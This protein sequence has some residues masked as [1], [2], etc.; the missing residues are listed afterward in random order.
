MFE[1]KVLI[2]PYI[3]LPIKVLIII[4]IL[5][6]FFHFFFKYLPLFNKRHLANIQRSSWSVEFDGFDNKIKIWLKMKD[7]RAQRKKLM[8]IKYKLVHDDDKSWVD[9]NLNEGV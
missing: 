2:G 8:E 5:S 3:L 7:D 4:F 1:F 9:K 6:I